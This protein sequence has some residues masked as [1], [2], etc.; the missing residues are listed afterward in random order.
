VSQVFISGGSARSQFIVETL[1][2]ELMV[3]SRAWNPLAFMSLAVPPQKLAE[4]EQVAA[5][6]AVAVGGAMTVL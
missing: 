6:L 3:P 5:Q 1:Q 2:S 4:A